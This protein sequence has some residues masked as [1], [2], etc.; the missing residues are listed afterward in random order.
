MDEKTTPKVLITLNVDGQ[1]GG[2][3]VSHKRIMED[4]FLKSKYHFEVLW[5]PRSRSFVNPFFFLRFVREIKKQKPDIV[6]IAGLQLSGFFPML[7]CQITNSKTVLAIHG[8]STE[9]LDVGRGKK[10]VYRSL[11]KYTVRKAT[12]AYGV[13]KY[14]SSWE[15][16]KNSS[17]YYGTIYNLPDE[18]EKK[19][20]SSSIRAE[21][22]FTSEDII[23]VSTGRITRDK[24]FDTLCSVVKR[25]KAYPNVKFVIAGDGGYKD[26]FDYEIEKEGMRE[27]VFLL[28]FRSDI[29]DILKESDIFII[30]SKHE[31]LCISALEAA[32]A[33]LPLIVSDVGGLPEIVDSSCGFLVNPYDVEK[34][35]SCLEVLVLS[36]QMRQSM[37]EKASI[38]VK[39]QFNSSRIERQIDSLY[40]SVIYNKN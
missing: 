12:C 23:V 40:Q 28:G 4:E 30:C 13:S 1:N 29:Y 32:M 18:K 31:T 20:S 21:L 14:V 7:A 19:Q 11:E 24:G 37:G 9:A 16:A 15:I 3:Y 22:K 25:M 26:Q 2:P 34:F 5:V 39:N 33:G 10:R 35:V 17:H 27:Q 6:H 38:K 8:S 36:K